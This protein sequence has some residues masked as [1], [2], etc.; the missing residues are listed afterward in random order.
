MY[1]LIARKDEKIHI[2][3]KLKNIKTVF[4]YSKHHKSITIIPGPRFVEIYFQV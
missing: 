1:S 4:I 2:H 3:K